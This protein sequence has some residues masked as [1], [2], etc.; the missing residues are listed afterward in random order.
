MLETIAVLAAFF[1]LIIIF[2][3]FYSNA[4]V[5]VDK[6]KGR[7]RQLETINVMKQVSSLIEVQCSERGI[8]KDGCIDLLKANAASEVMQN[9]E[10]KELYFDKF[11]FSRIA[12]KQIY[13]EVKDIAVIYDN[14]LQDY[15]SKDS[16]NIPVSLYDPIKNKYYFG[17]ITLEIFSK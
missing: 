4:A 2:Y 11:G 9:A 1:I 12:I 8:V 15:S 3:W 17:A 7:M 16:S 14:S 5:D 6:E 10:N 13:P